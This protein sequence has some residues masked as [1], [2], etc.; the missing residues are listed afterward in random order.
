MTDGHDD[1]QQ[2]PQGYS[3]QHREGQPWQPEQDHPTAHLPHID[4]PQP[5]YPPQGPPYWEQP[6]YAAQPGYGQGYPPP[7]PPGGAPGGPERPKPWAA[8]HK[9]LTGL[10]VFCGFVFVIGAAAKA[11]SSSSSSRP[12][13]AT[14]SPTP[15]VPVVKA[16]STTRPTP[17]AALTSTTAAAPSTPAQTTLAAQPAAPTT[18][19]ATTPAA[20][21]AVSTAPVR[22]TP[23][24]PP[25]SAPAS[26][27]P[28]SDEGTCYEPGEYCRDDDRGVSGVAGDGEAIICENKD[29]L[30]WEPA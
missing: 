6:G 3:P 7:Q 23:A 26:C 9:V 17:T 30:R 1:G 11:S 18:P 20:Q 10:L 28:L 14:V 24:P 8:R 19:V 25:S 21:P 13:A 12:A 15:K 5:P 16:R 29:G 22:T 27:Y 2:P 4:A